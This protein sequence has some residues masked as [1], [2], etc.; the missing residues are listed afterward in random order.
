MN[1]LMK[2][3]LI[4]FLLVV[5]CFEVGYADPVTIERAQK[6]AEQFF[7]N[8]SPKT[9]S[10]KGGVSLVYSIPEVETKASGASPLLYV[11]EQIDGGYVIISGE[12]CAHPV[13]GYSLN[14]SFT[15][16]DIP[17]NIRSMLKWYADIIDFARQNNWAPSSE[18]L[19][20]WNETENDG[21]ESEVVK[22]ETA[23]WNQRSPNNDLCPVIDGQRCPSGCVATATSIIM[24][25]HEWPQFGTGHLNSYDYGWN[26][27]EYQYHIEGYDLGHEYKWDDMPVVQPEGGYTER[28]AKQIA[29]L[30]YDVGVMLEMDY[31]P[32]GSGAGDYAV[33]RLTSYFN[34]DKGMKI[35]FREGYSEY[36]WKGII[37][38][39]INSKRPIYYSGSGYNGPHAFVIDGYQ[40]NYFSVNYG[41]GGYRNGFY[42]LSPIVGHEEDLVLYYGSQ[43]MIYGI[44]PKRE[45]TTSPPY[46]IEAGIILRDWDVGPNHNF[47][48]LTTAHI[49][50]VNDASQPF[51]FCLYLGDSEGN[52]KERISSPVSEI[53]RPPKNDGTKGA[54]YGASL[55]IQ[56][57]IKS[58]IEEGDIIMLYMKSPDG[59]W[60]R[61]MSEYGNYTFTNTTTPIS[62]LTRVGISSEN[63]FPNADPIL[64][65]WIEEHDF[66]KYVFY[67][68]IHNNLIFKLIDS[69]NSVLIGTNTMHGDAAAVM[70]GYPEDP[71]WTLYYVKLPAGHY[72]L[73][74]KN[75]NEEVIIDI[76]I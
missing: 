74:I 27:S 41:W 8:R 37:C 55:F 65:K 53:L 25:Y 3:L 51:E 64:W 26:G 44:Q 31:S 10:S 69:Q 71:D 22:L 24:R 28:Q 23:Q 58:S 60:E 21:I 43:A 75:I 48:L 42:T 57:S 72:Q 20:E 61:L 12:E 52:P 67:V 46:G 76:D 49:F 9:K 35:A 63:P 56:G 47:E 50:N 17:D 62:E 34:Y 7:S 2:K 38:D 4:S 11:F 39:E 15:A 13:L 59:E 5:L 19:A 32:T 1:N 70:G 66:T 68:C 18:S 54:C 40:G 45:D 16:N 6:R 33:L 36:P 14:G 73:V 29:Q 30:L